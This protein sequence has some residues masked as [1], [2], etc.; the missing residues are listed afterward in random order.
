[1]PPSIAEP[2]FIMALRTSRSPSPREQT[3]SHSSP[4]EG[5][6]NAGRPLP[7]VPPRITVDESEGPELKAESPNLRYVPGEEGDAQA[8]ASL[9]PPVHLELCSVERAE[10]VEIG[11]EGFVHCVTVHSLVDSKKRDD[12][13]DLSDFLAGMNGG[14]VVAKRQR[15]HTQGTQ[16]GT[17]DLKGKLHHTSKAS[18]L[19]AKSM[20]TPVSGSVTLRARS[21]ERDATL[22]CAEMP[23]AKSIGHNRSASQ[24][25]HKSEAKNEKGPKFGV[26]PAFVAAS[27]DRKPAN[28]LRPLTTKERRRTVREGVG[29]LVPIRK[30]R[31]PALGRLANDVGR[32][33]NVLNLKLLER[34]LLEVDHVYDELR[35]MYPYD[36]AA[37][38]RE[39]EKSEN[40]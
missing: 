15:F 10:T 6:C 36:A 7:V 40:S 34:E 11:G 9:T 24:V 30:K 19:A 8:T 37:V 1:M 33:A 39:Q 26:P 29:S 38:E 5:H 25:D 4:R 12:E 27:P 21:T 35:D 2:L 31:P 17:L 3:V 18:P 32:S 13:M 14:S 16:V 23:P 22:P 28:K 20:Q